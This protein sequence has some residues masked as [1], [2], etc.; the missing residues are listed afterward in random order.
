MVEPNNPEG[1]AT[2]AG[3]SPSPP[4]QVGEM[5]LEL[6]PLPPGD[7]ISG[8]PAAGSR[9]LG[10]LG[11]VEVGVWEMTAGAARDVEA[12]EIFVVLAGRATIEF[13]DGR[14]VVVGPGDV[15][16]LVQGQRTVWTVTEPLRKVYV[17]ASD[18]DED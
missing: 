14:S 7:V 8:A 9:T 2:D 12:D 4:V 17:T 10:R 6:E 13:D 1:I 15:M 16:T 3:S 11:S 5:A 18:T